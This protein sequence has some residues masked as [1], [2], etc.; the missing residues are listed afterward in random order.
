ML[1]CKCEGRVSHNT[2]DHLCDPCLHG[3]CWG[4]GW[5]APM[6][7]ILNSCPSTTSPRLVAGRAALAPAQ[8]VA[9]PSSHAAR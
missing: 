8:S 7:S 1:T 6:I 2:A 4:W 5:G 9:R 3:E